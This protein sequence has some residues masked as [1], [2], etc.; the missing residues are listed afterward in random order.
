[1]Y[2]VAN[3]RAVV[4]AVLPVDVLP[5]AVVAQASHEAAA[6]VAVAEALLHV[7]DATSRKW[8]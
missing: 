4:R 1:M 3:L 5:L 6:V 2:H 8:R 7:E